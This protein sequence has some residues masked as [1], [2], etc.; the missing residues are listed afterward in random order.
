M[1][2]NVC[3]RLDAAGID[4]CLSHGYATYPEDVDPNDVDI[5]VRREHFRDI[6]GVISRVPSVD[7]VQFRIHNGGAAVRYDLVSRTPER[8]P[9]L[10]GIDVF[11]DIRDLGVLLMRA[12][13]FFV[14]RRRFKEVFWIPRPSVEFGHYLLK[15]LG[16]SAHFG[17]DALDGEHEVCLSRL[18]LED[19]QGCRQQ[20]ARFFPVA[21]AKLIAE[22]AALQRWETVRA[23]IGALRRAAARKMRLAH[24]LNLVRYWGGDLLKV[25]RRILQPTGIVV[26][27]LGLDGS[28]KSATIERIIETLGHQAFQ[29]EK[30]YH[31]R[32]HLGVPENDEVLPITGVY[33]A[34]RGLLLSLAKLALW[35]FDYAGGY[36]LD[37]LPRLVR[38]HLIL[39]DRYYDDLLVDPRRYRFEGPMGL[40]R[41]MGRCLPRPNLLIVLDCPPELACPRKPGLGAA[42]AARQRR[43]Y[44]AL[45]H[46]VRGGHVVDASGQLDEVVVRVEEIIL[47]YMRRRTGRRLGLSA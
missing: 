29:S 47:N 6:P 25:I 9:V 20:L 38:S 41:V 42:E 18:Y 27:F 35:W 32:P 11:S 44:L 31:V 34:P 13:E 23:R 14:G 15:K 2:L 37:I 8:I 19:P 33:E 21:E 26:A 30:R 43:A 4:W 24:P 5:V 39:F 36:V 3:A 46:G 17:R 22:A 40:A 7:L 45:A 1:L 12:E 10:L 28:G 16:K